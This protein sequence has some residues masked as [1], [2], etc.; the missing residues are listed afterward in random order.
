MSASAPPPY[1]ETAD[2]LGA[3]DAD[4]VPLFADLKI[5]SQPHDPYSDTCLVHLKLLFAFQ[6]LKED[7]G[8]TDGLFGIW[9]SRADGAITTAGNGEV[10]EHVRPDGD[11][12]DDEEKRKALSKIREKRWA[13]FVARAVDRYEAWWNSLTGGRPLTEKDMEQSRTT[14]YEAFGLRKDQ[15]YWQKEGL[16]P[17][18]TYYTVTTYALC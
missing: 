2:A 13:L 6:A 5:D 11:V 9:D 17:L 18:G 15:S 3:Q 4:P 1:E 14:A 7:V 12:P 16:P 8:Y 10:E